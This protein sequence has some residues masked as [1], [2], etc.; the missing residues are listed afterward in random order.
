MLTD[1][2]IKNFAIIDDLHIAFLPGFTI[3][4]GETGTGKS[5]IIGALNLILGGRG[6]VEQIRTG[7]NEATVEALFDISKD[8]AFKELLATKS[9]ATDDSTLLVKRILSREGKNKILINGG[10]AT[11][12]ML[13][14][15]MEPLLNISGQ[16]EHQ[17]L[18]RPQNHIDTL[19][20]FGGLLTQRERYHETFLKREQIKRELENLKAEKIREA[21]KKELFSFERRE[22]ED[23]R[24]TPG[25]EEKLKKEKTILQNAE[26]LMRT[27]HE[28]YESLY[29]SDEAVISHLNRKVRDLKEIAAVDP[30]LTPFSQILDSVIIQLEDMAVS[31]RD[32]SKKIHFDPQVFEEID[33]RLETI[34]RLKRKYGETIEAILHY[35]EKI[36]AE[37]ERISH[38]D[39]RLHVLE[40]DYT[41]ASEEALSQATAL[42][43][44][45]KN[46]A[47]ELGQ[48]MEKELAT[49]SMQNTRFSVKN[50]QSDSL[51]EKGMDQIE[52]LISPNPGEELRPLARIASGG[53]LSRLMLAFKHIF[54]QEEKVSTL[55]FDEVDSGIGGATAEVVGKKLYTIS[56]YYQTI[57]ITHLP[58]IACFGDNQYSITKK[59]EAGRTKTRVKTLKAED[60]IEEIARMLGGA[61][62]TT[63]TRTLAREMIT[64]AE[65][66]AAQEQKN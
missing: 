21:E 64:S 49:L 3:L 24:L 55:I 12:G 9:L 54:A 7:E 66:T 17:E 5:I 11:L 4:S 19:D 65:K 34:H 39:D 45:R 2:K 47:L 59:I 51:D 27:S 40:E 52:F 35:Q 53:E 56:R 28:V 58:Q 6:F 38:R 1:L 48:K 43:Q 18:L 31:L 29:G 16:H 22:I 57:C 33:N 42:S 14:E 30:A 60:R 25:E 37:M 41:K 61:E 23:A 62:I 63:Q 8:K 26:Q 50:I 32:Y 10:L 20:S 36:E 46:V 15:I 44:K 13:T